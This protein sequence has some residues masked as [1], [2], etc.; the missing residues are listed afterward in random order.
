MEDCSSKWQFLKLYQVNKIKDKVS[1]EATFPYYLV[2]SE[3]CFEYVIENFYGQYAD[4]HINLTFKRRVS[5][6]KWAIRQFV[7][8][9]N[10]LKSAFNASVL[11]LTMNFVREKMR[12][13][14]SS[15]HC[16]SSLRIHAASASWIHSYFDNVMTKFMINN[17]ADA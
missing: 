11:L 17:R 13:W 1:D 6:R 5:E 14:F 7:I 4:G 16:Q 15:E 8:V 10:K 12:D 2:Q 9:K 3:K